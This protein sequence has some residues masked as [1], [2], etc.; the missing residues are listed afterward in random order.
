MK[1]RLIPLVAILAVAGCSKI[2]EEKS[3]TLE[4]GGSHSLD[5]SAPL[6]EQK[7]KVAL[8]SDEPVNIYV[9]LSKS[10]EGKTDFDP[11]SMK[12]G[13]LAKEKNIKSATLTATVPAKEK[14]L[15]YVDGATKKANVSVKVDSQ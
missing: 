11:D 13:V 15:I 9:L 1:A 14:Y 7:V 2:H 10:V 6:S 3:F 12:E 8:T 4:A 5:I